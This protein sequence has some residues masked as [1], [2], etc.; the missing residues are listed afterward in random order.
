MSF[1]SVRDGQT[2]AGAI[3]TAT[4]NSA[5]AVGAMQDMVLGIHLLTVNRNVFIQKKSNPVVNMAYLSEIGAEEL[6]ESDEIFNAAVVSGGTFGI[7]HGYLIETE[8]L[9][10]LRIEAKNFPYSVCS[11]AVYSLD[12]SSLGFKL[13]NPDETP[14]HIDAYVNGFAPESPIGCKVR[15]MEKIHLSDQEIE[16]A[17]RMGMNYK[18]NYYGDGLDFQNALSEFYNGFKNNIGELFGSSGGFSSDDNNRWTT[19]IA[20]GGVN[21]TPGILA[22]KRFVYGAGIEFFMEDIGLFKGKA[23]PME[24]Y[25]WDGTEAYFTFE[26]YPRISMEVGVSMDDV[27]TVVDY[28]SKVFYDNPAPALFQLRFVKSSTANLCPGRYGEVTAHVNFPSFDIPDTTNLYNKIQETLEENRD[29]TPFTYHFGK[30]VPLNAEVHQKSYGEVLVSFK[31]L[32][33]EFLKDD[34]ET[35]IFSSDFTDTIGFTK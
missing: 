32:R 3:N 35:Y 6:I 11:K 20:A 27:G 25:G 28:L 17:K 18:P 21:N 29:N 9:F 33:Q 30:I 2:L 1:F 14:L 24:I 31:E 13:Q 12:V 4:H 23:Y 16:N 26:P 10:K 8:R 5:I 15:V 34:N 7:V 19:S 22:L